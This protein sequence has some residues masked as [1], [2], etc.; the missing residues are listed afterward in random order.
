MKKRILPVLLAL[1]L[2]F[3]AAAC[4]SGSQQP[5]QA[6][7]APAAAAATTAAADAGAAATE[8]PG[9]G[10]AATEAAATEAPPA[11]TAAAGDGAGSGDFVTLQV[12]SMPANVSG[13]Q[14][15]SYWAETLKA[16]LNLQIELLPAGDDAASKLAALMAS[17]DLPDVV[18]FKDNTT[19][20]ADAIEAGLILSLDDHQDLL[21][22]VYANAPNAL[23]YIR[24]TVSNGTGKA[25]AVPTQVTD[26]ANKSGSVTGPYLRWDLYKQ[27][28]MPKMAGI[29]DYL[30][31]VKQMLELEPTNPAGQ[32]NYGF[33]IFKDWDAEV[34]WPVRLISEMYGVTQD[35]FQFSE[36]NF[37]TG[38]ISSIYA[39]G[40][41]F[42]K[43]VKFFNK[44]SQM[45]LMDPDL[46]TG[47]F[48]DYVE[49][50]NAGR[51][52]FQ[53]L[54]WTSWEYETEETRN[55]MRSYKGVF[56]DDERMIIGTPPYVGGA[57]GNQWFAISSTS[58]HTERA[59]A[60]LNYMY[61]ADNLWKLAWGEKGIAWDVGADGLPYRTE[62]GWEMKNGNL[63]FDSG[64]KISD[65]LNVVNAFGL[66]WFYT[67]PTYGA[68]M[69]ELDWP[70]AADAPKDYAVD[71]DWRSATGAYDDIDYGY[72]N[73]L[74]AERPFVPPLPALP[75]D[76]KAIAD[77]VK[78]ENFSYT[79]QMIVAPD[80]AAFEALWAELV[81]RATGMGAETVNAWVAE[82]Y[83]I[84]KNEG[85]KYMH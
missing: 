22:N 35:G 50:V 10:A 31:V 34:S 28:G 39:D 75:D 11:E 73:G 7:D 82:Q 85:A 32:A 42:K 45:G 37:N 84:S 30:D 3:G 68:R 63:E 81:S 43:G 76:L 71:E 62:K 67:N 25:Y 13:M 6:T 53:L 46:V 69:D 70:K 38:G 16:D 77:Q 8:A 27:L 15:R 40:S 56:F 58:D 47:N 9:A 33:C 26:Q 51:S 80:D 54:S 14:D 19:Y 29:E 36:V 57:G 44:A 1:A 12:F 49:K 74:V 66:P 83:E 59:L 24:D 52:M 2:A 61:G 20:I 64:G 41:Y 4:N 65:G 23:Q 72:K 48:D 17:R 5:A 60:Y 78:A 21:P 55:S 18:V 79:Y